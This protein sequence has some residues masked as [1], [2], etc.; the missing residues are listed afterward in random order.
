MMPKKQIIK[1][2]DNYHTYFLFLAFL[3]FLPFDLVLLFG[4]DMLLFKIVLIAN[5][6]FIGILAVGRIVYPVKFVFDG[7]ALT[8]YNGKKI[9]YKIKLENIEAV[10]IQKGKKRSFIVF[11]FQTLCQL[12]PDGDYM[13]SISFVFNSYD[14]KGEAK[15]TEPYLSLKPKEYN[16]FY[17]RCDILSFRKCKRLCKFMKIT[18]VI[19]ENSKKVAR[20]RNL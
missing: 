2:R 5:S 9:V 16:R 19:L 13:T 15:N 20:R 17:E 1:P 6:I 4:F 11:I 18:P 3:V 12:K 8:K 14:I 7:E 10:F